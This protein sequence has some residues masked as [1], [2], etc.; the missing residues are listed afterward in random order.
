MGIKNPSEVLRIIDKLDKIGEENVREE[1]KEISIEENVIEQL[2]NFIRIQG[3]NEE[4]LNQLKEMPCQDEEFKA[5]VRDLEIVYHGILDFGVSAKYIALDLKIARGLD[6]YTGTVYETFLT[7]Y[8]SIGSVCSGGA[9]ENLASNY[10]TQKLPGVGISI[11]LSRLYY[12]LNEVGLLKFPIENH[13]KALIVPMG[14]A[15]SDCIILA[16][17]LRQA[18]IITQVYLEGGKTGKKFNYADKL[19]VPWV[20]VVGEEEINEGKYSLRNME[21]GEQE[22]LSLNELIEKLK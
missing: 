16:Q 2:M 6:Y 3:N 11:G 12:Q 4:I 10:T 1:L 5:G 22:K 15:E 21:N 17:K 8:E 18:G 13:L 19:N 20:V 7:G 9:Y 14:T